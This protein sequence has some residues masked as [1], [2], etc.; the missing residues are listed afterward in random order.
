MFNKIVSVDFTG[1]TPDVKKEMESLANE[2][3]FYDDY[4]TDNHVIIE[5]VKDADVILV[6]WNTMID[7]AVID[8]CE[9]LKYVGMCCSLIDENSA[10]V[11]IA[12]CK[13][14][15]IPVLGV[16]DYGD[17]GVAEF[18]IAELIRL[19]H[20]FGDYQWKKDVYE[21]TDFTL[22]IIGMGATGMML[23]E[24]AAAFGMKVCYYSRTKKDVP[25]EY[26][27]LDELLEKSDVL[28]T[29]LPRNT[30]VLHEGDFEKFGNGKIFVNTSLGQTFDVEDFK[31]W[32]K[33]SS[34]FA[35][36][37]YE[38]MG[39]MR[40]EFVK[41]GGLIYSNK[42]SGWTEQAKGRLSVKVLENLKSVMK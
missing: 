42:V 40:D 29:H 19:T 8:A 41:L 16:R 5:R 3:V 9:N 39:K 36:M 28:S 30:Q 11:D 21:I 27:T 15:N 32:M 31:K 26:M 37:D 10:N 22:G 23:A 2:V 4:P 13:E 12:A 1:M 20:G 17:E 18:I 6:S 38:A 25:Y 35:I 33:D 34:N 24:R 7:K 14:R